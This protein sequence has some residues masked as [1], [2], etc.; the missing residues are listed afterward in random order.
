[1]KLGPVTRLDKRNKTRSKKFDDDGMSKSC[2]IIAV[3]PINGQ[4]G[5]ICKP[6]SRRIIC[7]TYIFINSN[8]LYYKK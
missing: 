5:A 8:L 4:L 6:H 7:K 3:F 1:M 2:D